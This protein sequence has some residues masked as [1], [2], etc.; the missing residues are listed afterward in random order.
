MRRLIVRPNP[1]WNDSTNPARFHTFIDLGNNNVQRLQLAGFSYF[2]EVGGVR[3]IPAGKYIVLYPEHDA[4]DW[5]RVIN[6]GLPAATPIRATYAQWLAMLAAHRVNLVRIWL[7][8]FLEGDSYP[9][10]HQF[11]SDQYDLNRASQRYLRRLVRFVDLARRH[12]IVVHITIASDHMMRRDEATPRKNSWN[13]TPF[14]VNHSTPDAFPDDG[15]GGGFDSFLNLGPVGSPRYTILRN[16]VQSVVAAVRPYWNVMFELMNE[17]GVSRA[18]REEPLNAWH[19]TVASWLNDDLNDGAGKRTHLVTTSADTLN[20]VLDPLLDALFAGGKNLVDVVSLHGSQWGGR[21]RP[22]STQPAPPS[23][24]EITA[25]TSAALKRLHDRHAG[26]ALAVI[27]DT[28]AFPFAQDD[29]GRY[30][31]LTMRGQQLNFAQRWSARQLSHAQLLQQLGAIKAATPAEMVIFTDAS[32]RPAPLPVVPATESE[33]AGAWVERLFT[34]RANDIAAFRRE[35]IYIINTTPAANGFGVSRWTGSSFADV[36]GGA[37]VR[38]TVDG[39]GMPWTINGDGLIRRLTATGWVTVPGPHAT[40]IG[41]GADGSVWIIGNAP[42]PGGHEIYQ[43]TATAWQGVDGAALRI[44][45]DPIGR[46]WVVNAAGAVFYRDGNAWVGVPGTTAAD[47]AVG[48]DDTVWVVNNSFAQIS[49]WIGSG[50]RAFNASAKAIAVDHDGL[51]W[52]VN[53]SN[54]VVQREVKDAPAVA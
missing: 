6:G 38:I 3:H 18:A 14:H 11:G 50:W 34:A 7:F 51:P 48:L 20:N 41:A 10:F 54:V 53:G 52:Y 5:Q 40:D 1:A 25:A 9:F 12:G 47:I 32:P 49:Y 22:T 13:G 26:R 28:D 36:P 23:D 4:G 30:A 17:A 29:P 37:G 39:A 8:D 2:G 31:R 33:L 44:A 45:V 35:S 16:L 43:K 46:P 19:T 42:I 27:C 15:T 21:D 24:A